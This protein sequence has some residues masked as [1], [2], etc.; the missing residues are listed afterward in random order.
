[1]IGLDWIGTSSRHFLNSVITLATGG[2]NVC[3]SIISIGQEQ[4]RTGK[5]NLTYHRL[6]RSP[7]YLSI[8]L[9]IYLSCV[10]A[11]GDAR[12]LREAVMSEGLRSTDTNM[13]IV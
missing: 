12:I 5:R 13:D 7:L 8:Y 10:R 4:D 9:P 3:V 11:R 1:M 6:P 2:G